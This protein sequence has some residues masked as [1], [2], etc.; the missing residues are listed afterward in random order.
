MVRTTLAGLRAQ[1]RRL[2]LTSVAIMIGVGFLAGTLVYGDTARTA[3]YDDLARAARNVDVHVG[4]SGRVFMETARRVDFGALDAVRRVP[5]VARADGRIADRLPIVG[6]DGHVINNFGQIGWAV[7]VPSEPSLRMYDLAAGRLPVRPG[8]VALERST[9]D[10]QHFRIGG[11]VEVVGVDGRPVT[12]TIVGTIDL[13]ANQGFGRV[14]VA[15]LT[16]EDLRRLTA[17]AGYAEI[18]L[19]A[20]PGISQATLAARVS[21]ALNGRYDVMTGAQERRALAIR[22]AKYVDGFLAVLLAFSLVALA[23]SGFVIYNTFT[24]LVAQRSR[25]L[26]L[27]RCVG[28]SRGQLFGVV[29]V[30]SLVVGLLA[31]LGGLVLS[32]VFSLALL[33]GRNT[34]GH[35]VPLH[36]L[37]LR[38]LTVAVALG[39]G[40]LTTVLA[41][42]RPAYRAS[43]VSP[44][45]ALATVEPRKAEPRKAGPRRA[46]AQKAGPR[47]AGP[48]KAGPRRAGP[49]KG[50]RFAGLPGLATAAALVGAGAATMIIAAPRGFPGIPVVF[51]GGFIVFAGLAVASP[52]LVPALIRLVGAVPARLFGTPARLA[53]ANARRNPGRVAATTLALVV[54]LALMSTVSVLFA[55]VKVQAARELDENLA[56]DYVITGVDRGGPRPTEVPVRL[57]ADLRAR[58]ELAAAA[59]CRTAGA[60][61]DGRTVQVWAAE[62]GYLTGALRPEIM[63]GSFGAL[64]PGTAV[65]NRV[66]AGTIAAGLG[67]RIMV[68]TAGATRSLTVVATFDDTPTAGQALLDWSDYGALFGPGGADQVLVKA[69]NGVAPDRSRAAVEAALRGYPLTELSSQ[70]DW[71]AQLTGALDQQLAIFAALLAMSILIALCGI[72]NTVSLSVVERSRESALLRA[73]GLSSRGLGATLVIEAVL[74]SVVGGLIGITL[75][76]AVGYAAASGVIGLYGHGSP[77]VPVGQL[78]GYV[79]SAAVASAVAAVLPAR[80]AARVPVAAALGNT[81]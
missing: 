69:A 14:P 15:A 6:R 79:L 13:G 24:I 31:S 16:N 36:G 39:L 34:V 32:A 71:R 38:P 2:A 10:A 60:S 3:F 63:S 18:V 23:V 56:V 35:G 73:I 51:V 81:E 1:P 12:L 61:V 77:A 43:R 80:R 40:T 47:R 19:T 4:P 26:A 28:A 44:V 20:R 30:E 52:V 22:A 7:S 45:G 75:G 72:A 33:V 49:R 9:V 21:A 54:G 48:R 66:F 41:G 67:D 37:T 59:A 27:L 62:P 5:G 55:T 76:A 46:E 57:A 78:L 25:E 29:L 53:V 64:G 42:L 74:M 50:R 65:L 68:R 58:P 17:P 11:P 70:A 8:E